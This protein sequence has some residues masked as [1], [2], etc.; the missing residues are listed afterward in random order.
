[1]DNVERIIESS[2]VLVETMKKYL[3]I[4]DAQIER[5]EAAIDG[6]QQVVL[7]EGQSSTLP[8]GKNCKLEGKALFKGKRSSKIM[9]ELRDKIAA[10]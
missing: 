6:I 2:G 4:V 7:E 1:M 10:S 9:K 3:Y 8:N 5:L